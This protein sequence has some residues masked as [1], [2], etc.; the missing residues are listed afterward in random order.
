MLTKPDTLA[1]G[2]IKSRNQWLD[3][4]EGRRHPL[5][6]GYYCTRQPDDRERSCG[7]SPTAARDE[8]AEFFRNTTPWA[9]SFQNRLGT[10]TLVQN[11]SKVLTQII[12]TS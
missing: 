1:E 10:P 4:L 3:V 2:S 12:Q 8:E 5:L 6:H 7:I 9:T 11:V